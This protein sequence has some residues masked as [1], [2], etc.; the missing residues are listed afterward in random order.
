M[1]VPGLQLSRV[2]RNGSLGSPRLG[3]PS[4]LA[5]DRPTV[6]DLEREALLGRS[7]SE[8]DGLFWPAAELER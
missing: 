4:V 2:T 7:Y 5:L 1:M 8:P 3:C 6:L